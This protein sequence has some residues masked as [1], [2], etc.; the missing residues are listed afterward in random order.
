MHVDVFAVSWQCIWKTTLMEFPFGTV[1]RRI[2]GS[3][4]RA[5]GRLD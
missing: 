2:W 3:Q 1:K 4:A 5:H